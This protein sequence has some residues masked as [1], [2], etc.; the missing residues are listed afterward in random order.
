MSILLRSKLFYSELSMH[1]LMKNPIEYI[2]GGL[3]NT[4]I[5]SV[6]YKP[7]AQYMDR[8]GYPLFDYPNPSGHPDGTAWIHSM[9]MLWRSNHMM[10]LSRQQN[11]AIAATLNPWREIIRKNLATSKAVVDHYLA[12][13]VGD[14]VP[15]EVRSKL[16]TYM[17]SVNGG[18]P[19]RFDLADPKAVELKVRGLVHL[20]TLLPQYHVK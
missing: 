2:V 7:L 17:R 12:V 3:K 10:E 9:S 19:F 8:M 20:I 4:G 15:D 11:S 16:E 13:M 5:D 14:Y 6:K 1:R 18:I